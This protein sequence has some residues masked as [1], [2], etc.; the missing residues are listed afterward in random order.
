[1]RS[2]RSSKYV[3]LG[4]LT[5]ACAFFVLPMLWLIVSA[6]KPRGE[7]TAIPP[8]FSFH[9]TLANFVSLFDKPGFGRSV[10]NSVISVGGAVIFALLVGTPAAYVLARRRFKGRA[11]ILF[12]LLSLEMLPPIAII[13]PLYLTFSHLR[14]LATLVP[15]I[16][17]FTL[18]DLPFH[19]WMMRGFFN[20]VPR[21][22]EEAGRMDG[23]TDFGVF[24]KI[25]LRLVFGGLFTST[26]F[27][28]IFNWGA[29]AIPVLLSQNGSTLLPAVV[30]SAVGS[31]SISWGVLLAGVVVMMVPLLVLALFVQRY[32]VRGLSF[33]AIR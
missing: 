33:G 17:S 28:T 18:F 14:L 29:Y 8:V 1:M 21:G 20:E 30:G 6:F 5:V 25:S 3:W 15:V 16:V 7:I 32:V 4:V 22:V 23:L 31:V 11:N 13:V 10:V 24:W 9:P 2:F 12:W 19:I 26:L 27:M